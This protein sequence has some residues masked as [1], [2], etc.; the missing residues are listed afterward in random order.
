M[1]LSAVVAERKTAEAA[2]IGVVD[3]EVVVFPTPSLREPE[4]LES[5]VASVSAVPDSVNTIVTI[6]SDVLDAEEMVKPE[7]VKSAPATD[8]DVI[9]S[10]NVNR[11]RSICPSV[12][13]SA[14]VPERSTAIAASLGVFVPEAV[15]F[16]ALS[17]RDPAT[18]VEG[19]ASV[20]ALPDSVSTI[21]MTE[22]AVRD[23]EETVKPE[24]VK[25]APATDPDV[26]SS[27]NVRTIRS[28]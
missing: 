21:V 25:S 10:L 1:S 4:T 11:I 27:L 5:G 24:T 16:D 3:P 8:P 2:S 6:E 19:V 12:S 22:S 17:L 14:V 26:I 13:L 9:S 18:L 28:I 20:S 23:A 15:V 7:T